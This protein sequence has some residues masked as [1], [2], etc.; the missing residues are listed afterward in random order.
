[1]L[2]TE[3]SYGRHYDKETQKSDGL[4]DLQSFC[5]DLSR[6]TNAAVFFQDRM[7]LNEYINYLAATVLVQHWDCFNKNHFLLYDGRN[8]K[9]WLV[10]PWDLDRTLGD[11]WDGS[12]DEARLPILLGTR[13]LP[14]TSG[15][16][17]PADRFL[18]ETPV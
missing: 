6:A 5:H 17:R 13:Q 1:D 8:S 7:D 10:V 2:G 3:R 16:N 9:K 11:H 12:F 18:V 15:W 4:G 14:G